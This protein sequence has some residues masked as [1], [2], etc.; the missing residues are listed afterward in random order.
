MPPDTA[1]YH[2]QAW[3]NLRRPGRTHASK[4]MDALA[5]VHHSTI[6]S[7]SVDGAEAISV[8]TWNGYGQANYSGKY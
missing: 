2:L 8:R 7:P 5:H 3:Q 1:H 4:I 6:K